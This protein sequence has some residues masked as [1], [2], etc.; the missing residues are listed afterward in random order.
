MCGSATVCVNIYASRM[1][2][3]CLYCT[4][5][6]LRPRVRVCVSECALVRVQSVYTCF[7]ACKVYIRVS[8][9]AKCI[10]VF[11]CVVAAVPV[12]AGLRVVLLSA[13][14]NFYNEKP[15]V[16]FLRLC[17][18][19]LSITKCVQQLVGFILQLLGVHS[20][21]SFRHQ[22]SGAV[23]GTSLLFITSA[24]HWVHMK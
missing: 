19:T 24:S 9:R 1:A 11:P 20:N 18:W 3:V 22:N 7:R 8:V 16:C 2:C 5:V 13:V 14:C 15:R 23:T 10:Y 12:A 6:H 21:C 4:F 17:V